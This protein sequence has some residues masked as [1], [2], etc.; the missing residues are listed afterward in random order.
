MDGLKTT[1]L[2]GIN[3]LLMG[4]VAFGVDITDEQ[5]VAIMGIAGT[6]IV[7]IAILVVRYFTAAPMVGL[8]DSQRSAGII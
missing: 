7:P 2:A 4:V 3:S 6:V 5:K 8:E 1:L